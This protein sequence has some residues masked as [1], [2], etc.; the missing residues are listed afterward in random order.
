MMKY[1]FRTIL[2]FMLV[3]SVSACGVKGKL[4]TPDQ[5]EKQEAKET[6]KKAK[7]AEDTGQE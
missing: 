6:A 7:E 2:F 3:V 5:I 4:K 1:I